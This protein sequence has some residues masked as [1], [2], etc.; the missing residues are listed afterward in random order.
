MEEKNGLQKIKF[1]KLA[2]LIFVVMGLAGAIVIAYSTNWGAIVFSD[3]AEYIL[4]ARS[5]LAGKG[6]GIPGPGGTFQSLTLH[7]PLYPLVLSGLSL[8]GLEPLVGARWLN[9]ILFGGVITLVSG[10]VYYFSRKLI[11]SI[12]IGLVI[13]TSPLF[14]EIYSSALAEPLFFLF[15]LMSLFLLVEYLGFHKLWILI[16][17]GISAGLACLTRYT[18]F[19]IIICGALIILAFQRITWKKRLVD[20]CVFVGTSVGLTATWILPLYLHTQRFAARS[21]LP[22]DDLSTALREARVSL[23]DTGWSWIPFSQFL[24]PRPSYFIRGWFM[25]IL[26]VILGLVTLFVAWK[27]FRSKV[28]KPQD[29]RLLHLAGVFTIFSIVYILFITFS[30]FFLSPRNDL[31]G[32]LLSPVYLSLLIVFSS[33]LIWALGDMKAGRWLVWLPAL[34][35]AVIVVS[36]FDKGIE[37]VQYNHRVGAGYTSETWLKSPTIRALTELDQEVALISNQ[38]AAILF[39]IGRPVYD[40][41]EQYRTTPSEK[42]T[43]YGDDP[44]DPAQKLFREG[45]ALLVIYPDSFYWQLFPIYGDRTQERLDSL[46][47][48][49]QEEQNLADGVIYRYPQP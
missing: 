10:L 30:F 8:V 13:L 44:K 28:N 29:I 38:S 9:I 18:G 7:P 49:L 26:L 35:L 25:I 45:Q 24:E 23:I 27:R 21:F 12:L 36:A 1:D 19:V 17:A 46:L 43:L 16:L 34:G 47:Q 6:L 39:L 40:V 20:L 14:L 11:L 32:R 2:L 37:F 31:N 22:T 15:G 4:S 48:S 42:F 5:L 41:S 33:L 3:A